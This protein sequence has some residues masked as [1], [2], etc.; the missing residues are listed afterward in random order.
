[1]RKYIH[2]FI[3][4]LAV[5]F[6]F[7]VNMHGQEKLI[8]GTVASTDGEPLPGVSIA[9][10]GTATG[11]ITDVDGNFQLNAESDDVLQFSF[12]GFNNMEVPVGDQT[13]LNIELEET[14]VAL[15]EVVA[16][17][18]GRAKKSDLTSSITSVKGEDMKT[19][20]VGN[21]VEALQGKAP[22]VQIIAGSGHPGASPKVL[23]R[24]F[25]SLNLST[26]P[27]YVVDGVPMGNN[28]NFLNTNE[29]ESIEVLKDASASAIY[30]SRASNGV[31]LIS[32]KRG[33]D[34]KTLFSAD[35]SYGFQ[36][37]DKP[38]DM[39]NATEY[40]QI[41]NQSLQNAELGER[42]PDPASLGE[43]TDW[44]GEGVNKVSPQRNFSFQ[45][46]G[47]SETN[48]YAV[49]LNYYDQD[50]FYNSGNWQKF[51][52]RLSSD[53]DFAD[54]ITAGVMLNPRREMWES[55]PNWYQDYLLIDPVTPIYRPSEEQEGL[56]EYSIYQRSYYTYVWNP[57][58]RD[59]RQFDEGGYYALAA[60]AYAEVTPIK[61]LD[62]RT[63]ISGDYK[64]D[65]N[66]D[67][68]P[69]FV[70]DGAHEKN[71]L[72]YAYRSHNFNSYWNWTNTLT[73][74]LDVNEHNVSLMGGATMEKWEGRFINGTKDGIPNNSDPLRE[75]DAAT[76]NPEV[77]GNSWGNS[78]ESYLGRLSYNYLN[79]YYLTATYR[80]DGSSKFL[81]NNKWASF[82]SASVAWR[83]SD[84]SF[85]DGLDFINDLKI[86]AGW[87]R[88]GNQN[89]PSSVY[90][91]GIG[92]DYYVF[93]PGQGSLVNTTYPSSMKNEDIKWETVEDINLGTDFT[94]FGSQVNG[95][96]EYYQKKTKDM[97][98]QLP[99]PNYS[100]YPND[101]QI[102]SNVGSMKSE[103]VE[104]GLNYQNRRG[105]LK[106]D[107]GVTFT[108]VSVE[109]TDL[110]EITPVVYGD[111]ERTKTVE[112]EEPGY[113]F[114]YQT[115]GIFQN[116][117]EINSHASENGALL[118]AQAQPGDIRFVDVNGDGELNGEDRTK[119]G[120]PWPDFTG[121][122]NISLAYDNFDFT[123]NLYASVG[124]ELVNWLREDLYST[125]SS[126]NNV[127]S[128]L[129]DEAWHGEGTSNDIP[130]VSHT[131]LNQNFA[132]FSDYYVEDGSYMRVKN[133]QL[134]YSLPE[135][136]LDRIGL[137]KCRF[138]VSGQNILTVTNFEGVDPEVAGDNVLNFGFSGWTYPVL[139]TYL[140]GANITF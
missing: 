79:R 123:A 108:T 78:L 44:W 24:G 12:I 67:F 39:A 100:G 72:N 130:I 68:E 47:G 74:S 118:Q 54:W 60:N 46:S 38:Y 91:S 20:S 73:Y 29:I 111:E 103:G 136:V 26:D 122:L 77:N 121:G 8:K 95:S 45:A 102:W 55:T 140:I 81:A 64:F 98:F 10:K 22:G 25:T 13:I 110:P 85:M 139:P 88:L 48:R 50:S 109:A 21:P 87:G 49:S 56:N 15:D 58:A 92:Q 133:V 37:F 59:A 69:D 3:W 6:C 17:G 5:L 134:G 104:M 36:V 84:E 28:L 41:M 126:D 63:Q 99:Y 4:L 82:P 31:V 61:N 70:I 101:A 138:Y 93:G 107:V 65:H 113:F 128:G 135:S 90:T 75:I 106:Y 120:S 7:S 115:N 1:M 83:I 105:R 14:F 33:K 52:A 16:I 34:G 94:L 124:N 76:E 97:I 114:G 119:I 30:G 40:A 129:L 18:Y 11:T 112:G 35:L 127:I 23:I 27:L 96:V 19:M 42:F 89:L 86:R 117:F 71:E 51:T 116:Q 53:W 132:R 57:I 9:I 137:T 80:V 2:K 66:D 32:T 43:G 62:F 131:D 125:Q